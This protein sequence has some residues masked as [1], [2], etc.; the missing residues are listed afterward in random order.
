MNSIKKIGLG[1]STTV[2]SVPAFA[3]VDVTGTVTEIGLAAVA[4]VAIGAA[5]I[6]VKVGARVYKWAAAA[7]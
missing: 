4:V 1:L 6:L 2:L 5:V 7:L 3:A